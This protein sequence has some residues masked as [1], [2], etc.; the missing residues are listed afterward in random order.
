MN[1]FHLNCIRPLLSITNDSNPCF[2]LVS[3]IVHDPEKFILIDPI[4]MEKLNRIT[5]E[6]HNLHQLSPANA[7]SNKEIFVR[8][9]GLYQEHLSLCIEGVRCDRF[10]KVYTAM[11]NRDKI[12]KSVERRFVSPP[13][14]AK[15]VGVCLTGY[16]FFFT[17]FL[18]LDAD[19]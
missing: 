16:L 6:V 14:T 1:L 18:V 2:D 13:A 4:T 10:Y 5:N 15:M 19:R 12:Q 11:G 7:Q 9:T 17:F 3:A 8:N